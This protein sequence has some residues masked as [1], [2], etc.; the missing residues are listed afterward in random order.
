VT[1]CVPMS[2]AVN[3]GTGASGTIEAP[4]QPNKGVGLFL[5]V[6]LQRA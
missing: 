4:A 1:L 5:L 6:T 2:L 3:A